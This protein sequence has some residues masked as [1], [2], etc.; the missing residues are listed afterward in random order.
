M[1]PAARAKIAAALIIARA[2]SEDR[3]IEF[4]VLSIYRPARVAVKTGSVGSPGDVIRENSHQLK[5]DG[6]SST[7]FRSRTS[8]PV[9][10]AQERSRPRLRRG[11]RGARG[12]LLGQLAA[13]RGDV[14]SCYNLHRQRAA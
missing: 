4:I 13:D 8:G 5:R 6:S 12:F 9:S 11:T 7:R 14:F 10:L 1:P 2:A 3:R